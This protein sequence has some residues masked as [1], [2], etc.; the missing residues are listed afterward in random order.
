[1]GIRMHALEELPKVPVDLSLEA[2]SNRS[3]EIFEVIGYLYQQVAKIEVPMT[4][5]EMPPCFVL[6][7][8]EALSLY[9]TREGGGVAPGTPAERSHE[10]PLDAMSDY[11][12]TM[13]C[14]DARSKLR[15]L[16]IESA[17]KVALVAQKSV[18]AYTQTLDESISML[19]SLLR[20]N[21]Q[22]FHTRAFDLV[23]AM[24]EGFTTDQKRFALIEIVVSKLPVEELPLAFKAA[25]QITHSPFTEQVSA[26]LAQ[27]VIKEGSDGKIQEAKELIK[28]AAMGEVRNKACQ[29]LA[30]VLMDRHHKW[31]WEILELFPLIDSRAQI[32][33]IAHLMAK[34]I[35]GTMKDHSHMRK[36]MHTRV[37][38][39][40]LD[41]FNLLYLEGWVMDS[42]DVNWH[43]HAASCLTLIE[44]RTLRQRGEQLIVQ[45]LCAR[46]VE[47][48]Y[49]LGK[50]H[51]AHLKDG[52][53]DEAYAAFVT[54]ILADEKLD[55]RPR[56]A[57][58]AARAIHCA[59]KKSAVSLQ[60][61][62][63]CLLMPDHLWQTHA[64]GSAVA[65]HLGAAAHA[66]IAN[67]PYHGCKDAIAALQPEHRVEPTI[68]LVQKLLRVTAWRWSHRAN[69][70]VRSLPD[71]HP[72]RAE[73]QSQ[74]AAK[75]K[76]EHPDGWEKK[77]RRASQDVE[78]IRR[79]SLVD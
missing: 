6:E 13:Q 77:E 52:E 21:E 1:M 72:A 14:E 68:K 33:A 17:I 56:R 67:D 31:F 38:P 26:L 35:G 39:A 73:L 61:F 12:I 63:E 3:A 37:S 18:A 27:G 2:Y 36:E 7:L 76:A 11:P 32:D 4:P 48:W 28:K 51:L 70:H 46:Q 66:P 8:S 53:R 44:D 49:D 22:A 59:Q 41:R 78:R 16:Y 75:L 40:G 5:E 29:E 60:I 58:K 50:A 43:T 23:D 24:P 55:E 62:S 42:T 54:A 64:G 20:E 34:K 74:I 19:E 9:I 79:K 57:N 30:K 71:A 25:K 10:L 69:E 65:M 47:G 45:A 15:A